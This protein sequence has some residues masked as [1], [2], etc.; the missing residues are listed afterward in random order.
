MYVLVLVFSA[1]FIFV[2]RLTFAFRCYSEYEFTWWDGSGIQHVNGFSMSHFQLKMRSH[3]RELSTIRLPIKEAFFLVRLHPSYIAN[4]TDEC[5]HALVSAHFLVS[6]FFSETAPFELAM[7]HYNTGVSLFNRIPRVHQEVTLFAWPFAELKEIVEVSLSRR[8][9]SSVV[10]R[11]ITFVLSSMDRDMHAV[12]EFRSLVSQSIL[13][14]FEYTRAIVFDSSDPISA[15]WLSMFSSVHSFLVSLN[16]TLCHDYM[17]LLNQIPSEWY[18]VIFIDFKS[19]YSPSLLSNLVD[20]LVHSGTLSLPS[21]YS[22]GTQRSIAFIEDGEIRK[23][24]YASKNFLIGRKLEFSSLPQCRSNVQNL[25]LQIE[26]IIRLSDDEDMYFPLR[27]DDGSV[28]RSLRLCAGNEHSRTDWRDT[29]LSPVIPRS[30]V[31]SI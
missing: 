2:P 15:P 29:V 27:C 7:E 19:E 30:P 9:R 12:K 23:G 11:N 20:Y 13:R 24:G 31:S 22:L 4:L 6:L 21:F 26:S 28:P 10:G 17:N 1:G 16:R 3:F 18:P 14:S 8:I 25:S 5:P